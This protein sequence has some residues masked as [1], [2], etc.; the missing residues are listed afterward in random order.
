MPYKEKISAAQLTEQLTT[1]M[2]FLR[3]NNPLLLVIGE[4]GSGKTR[5]LSSMVAK[6]RIARH[7][8]RLKGNDNINAA[9]LIKLFTKNWTHLK[10][11]PNP[12]DTKEGRLEIQ[13]GEILQ[14]IVEHEHPCVFVVD[15]A[16]L[17]P[18]SVLAAIIH[19][20][21]LQE[22]HKVFL[23]LILSGKPGLEEKIHCLW[24]HP[25]E[26]LTLGKLSREEVYNSVKDRLAEQEFEAPPSLLE[27]IANQV[28]EQ[29]N[30]LP[31]NI[32]QLLVSLIGEPAPVKKK[33]PKL[34]LPRNKLT[35]RVLAS[36][37]LLLFGV[38]MWWFYQKPYAMVASHQPVHVV[39]TK[40]TPKATKPPKIAQVYLKANQPVTAKQIMQQVA[41]E[42]RQQMSVAAATHAKPS[43]LIQQQ[44]ND[45]ITASSESAA[46][47]YAE[48]ALQHLLKRRS[49]SGDLIGGSVNGPWIAR[50]RR[51][52]TSPVPS[53]RSVVSSPRGV[54]VSSS[55]GR[56]RGTHKSALS[57]H[58]YTLQLM[59]SPHKQHLQRYIN[60]HHLQTAAKIISTHYKHQQWYIIAYGHYPSK[61]KAL[62]A[63]HQLP[64]S[65][66]H[67][68]PWVRPL[69]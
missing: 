48:S 27:R 37:S 66:Q 52:M 13:L 51:A 8:I 65:L 12:T 18:I 1:L 14:S 19:L 6:M 3:S 21:I 47:R 34:S 11:T 54:V 26:T 68:H 64:R 43:D 31:E 41:K 36:T 44:S 4:K 69:R 63:Y 28:Y 30:G 58:I 10:T 33:K 67:L 60:Q 25:L 38:F 9:D 20:A 32:N 59:A 23:H 49:S 22:Q 62:A 56:D 55:R 17:L 5:L 16:H 45:S 61:Q 42:K 57:K 46:A 7:I 24:P 40:P 29:S 50:S 53:S 39:A 15:D 35:V 2:R